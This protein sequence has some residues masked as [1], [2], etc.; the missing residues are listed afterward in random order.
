MRRPL[1]SWLLVLASSP[2]VAGCSSSADPSATE[3]AP[4][5]LIGGAPAGRELAAVGQIVFKDAGGGPGRDV[6]SA[7]LIAPSLVLTARHCI[8]DLVLNNARVWA[9]GYEPTDM[10][11]A[12]HAGRK[13]V[14]IREGFALG[15]AAL[16]SEREGIS[17]C[18][19]DVALLALD[20]PIPASEVTPLALRD[21]PLGPEDEGKQLA[22]AGWGHGSATRR[23]VGPIR[24]LATSGKPLQ[25]K[26]ASVTDWHRHLGPYFALL[27]SQRATYPAYAARKAEILA[28]YDTLELSAGAMEVFSD[29]GGDDAR[30]CYGDSGGP[31]LERIDGAYRIVGVTSA[32]LPMI[33]SGDAC[34]YGGSFIT[35]GPELRAAVRQVVTD[36]SRWGRCA[37]WA[38]G[39]DLW[40]CDG[41]II[42]GCLPGAIRVN[43][44]E[45]C[46]SYGKVCRKGV[47]A[48]W[49]QGPATC[50]TP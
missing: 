21:T 26:F 4:A 29:F 8:R 35:I 36:V 30:T 1:P 16:C 33:R 38:T 41:D 11:D 47:G 12:T 28:Y 24:L 48:H 40:T 5:E 2:L 42:T 46:A 43:Y 22:V 17:W 6:C 37:E 44:R 10:T 31:L 34:A 19:Q 20:E 9:F 7:T 49:S 14:G 3:A 27:E 39:D 32:G 50:A 45:S 15:Q 23:R 18:G 13:L 25:K